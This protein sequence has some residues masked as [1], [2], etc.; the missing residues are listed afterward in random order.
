M[1]DFDTPNMVSIFNWAAS[2]A[3]EDKLRLAPDVEATRLRDAFTAYHRVDALEPGMIVRQ[4]PE[5]KYGDLL[6]SNGLWVVLRVLAKPKKLKQSAEVFDLVLGFLDES[7]D[8]CVHLAPSARY[9]PVPATDLKTRI[10][11]DDEEQ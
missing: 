3:G 5:V 1:S 2:M 9:E 10:D 8:F 11:E 7:E 4:K 6:S